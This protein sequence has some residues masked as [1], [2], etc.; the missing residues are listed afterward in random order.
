VTSQ[1]GSNA[2]NREPTALWFALLVLALLVYAT[3]LGGEYIPTN[4]DE[5]VY[6]HIARLTAAT[7]QW[8]PLASELDN[9][10]NTKPPALFWQAIVATQWG[11]HWSLLAL[12]LP[13]LLYTAAMT[14]AVAY[15]V[16]LITRNTRDALVAACTYLAFFCTFRYGRPFLTSAPETLWLDLPMLAVLWHSIRSQ[17]IYQQKSTIAPVFARLFAPYSI[18]FIIFC[19]LAWGVG[20]LYKSF[21]LIAPAAAAMWLALLWV[22][23]AFNWQTG[24][25]A[26]VTTGLSVVLAVAVFGL[27]FA[28]DPQPATIWRE[29]VVGENAGKMVDAQGYWHEA[30][31]GGGSSIWVQALSYAENAGLLFFVVPGLGLAVWRGWRASR[32]ASQPVPAYLWVLLAWLLVWWLVFMLPSQRSAR[33]VIP[34]MPAVAIL[35]GLYWQRIG[36]GWFVACYVLIG[37][38]L[39]AIGR[40]AWAAAQLRIAS[41]PEAALA[42]TCVAL[43]AIALVA[44]TFKPSWSR[45]VSIAA[46]LAVYASFN[47]T[48]AP[49]A[50]PQGRFGP[51]VVQAMAPFRPNARIAVPNNFRAQHERFEFLLPRGVRYEPFEMHWLT[52]T[53]KASGRLQGLLQIHDAVIWGQASPSD[54]A[55][56]CA[57]QCQVLGTRWVVKGRH[58]SGEITLGNLWQPEV[59]LFSR[60]WLVAAKRP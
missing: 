50:G 46:C 19:G 15:S 49:F 28:L 37:I 29:F 8:L 30:F 9:M 59:W 41:G 17:P 7:H 36:R 44:G 32:A 12:R 33:Y 21:A 47:A 56:P 53:D 40:I 52:E 2:A 23:P 1:S 14:A 42:L 16:H 51:E 22:A 27:W 60:E 5:L 35:L 26:S 54:T 18:A 31:Y 6:A 4:G 39:L 43:G 48:V 58:R 34:A 24:V 57:P 25:K 20:S 45:V 10:R 11:Q 55:P 38:A 13:S 3:G